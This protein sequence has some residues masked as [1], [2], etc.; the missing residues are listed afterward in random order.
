METPGERS[1]PIVSGVVQGVHPLGRRAVEG[2]H[3]C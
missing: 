3:K 2:T 1:I